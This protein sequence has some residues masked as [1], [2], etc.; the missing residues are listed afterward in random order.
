MAMIKPFFPL[1]T[2]GVRR[3]E[4]RYLAGRGRRLERG[5]CLLS[6][7]Y[8]CRIFGLGARFWCAATLPMR[9][10]RRG[11]RWIGLTPRPGI[12]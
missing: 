6:N 2:P 11:G 12:I 5:D 1:S 8:H 9:L 7:C 4:K 3:C 10:G